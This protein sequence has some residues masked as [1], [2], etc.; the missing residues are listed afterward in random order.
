MPR[1]SDILESHREAVL[2]IIAAHRG[3]NPRVFGS[4]ARGADNP[5]SDLDIS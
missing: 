2:R 1:P 5:R 4:V 3:L